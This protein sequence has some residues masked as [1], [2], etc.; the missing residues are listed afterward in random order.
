MRSRPLIHCFGHIHEGWGAERVK[1]YVLY[2]CQ[3]N[4]P[5]LIPLR[6]DDADNI[7][8]SSASISQWQD[9]SW[10]AGVA[11]QGS[12]IEKVQTDLDAAQ[13]HHAV[14]VDVS[15]EGGQGLKRGEE[16]LLVNAAIMDVE[17]SPVNAPWIVDI[18]L[19]K[20]LS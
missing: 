17:Y 6:S 8:D 4:A 15:K 18:D 7:A 10:K 5:V 11:E 9:G 16:T 20:A 13:E 1:W 3:F 14:F 19:P 12:A 2:R